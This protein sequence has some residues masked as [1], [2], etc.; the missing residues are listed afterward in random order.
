MMFKWIKQL[1][2]K[3]AAPVEPIV[4][5]DVW[6]LNS[7]DPWEDA[8]LKVVDYVPGWVRCKW[9]DQRHDMYRT[10]PERTFRGCYRKKDGE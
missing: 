6:V 5:G 1:F 10:V 2:T 8:A 3:E 9:V 7:G 4:V